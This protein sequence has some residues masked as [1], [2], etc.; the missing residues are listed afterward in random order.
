MFISVTTR[1]ANST[2]RMKRTGKLTTNSCKLAGPPK[3]LEVPQVNVSWTGCC[4]DLRPVYQH[5]E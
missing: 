3:N 2:S 5:L 1:N 4:G